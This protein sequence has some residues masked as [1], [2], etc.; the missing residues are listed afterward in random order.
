M[1][2]RNDA[3]GTGTRGGPM[4]GV[5]AQG[6]SSS[7]E[8]EYFVSRTI[9]VGRK[10]YASGLHGVVAQKMQASSQIDRDRVALRPANGVRFLP[11]EMDANES[12]RHVLW[13]RALG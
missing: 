12:L 9:S 8:Q 10:Q 13:T 5:V 7:F 6:T 4:S 2:A 3:C 1:E 11:L